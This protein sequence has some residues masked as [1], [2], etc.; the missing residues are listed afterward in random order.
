MI[1]SQP[2]TPN[3]QIYKFVSLII[4]CNLVFGIFTLYAQ[5]NNKLVDLTKTIIEAKNNQQLYPVFEELKELYLKENKYT[6]FVEFLESLATKK[7]DL[8]PVINY[9]IAFSRYYQLKHLEETQN[10]DEY[11]S[12]GNTYRDQI[13]EKA[14]D[15]RN[16]FFFGCPASGGKN[17]PL[18]VP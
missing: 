4:V 13:I 5:D 12:Q 11:F 1:N 9:Y 17:D 6:E 8:E 16:P 7:K 10:W 18:A 14:E 15:N 3:P 2:R